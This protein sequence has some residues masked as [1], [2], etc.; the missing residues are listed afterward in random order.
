[1]RYSLQHSIAGMAACGCATIVR[2]SLQARSDQWLDAHR[3][4]LRRDQSRC[5]WRS[6]RLSG[7]P[8]AKLRHS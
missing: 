6:A 8:K 2:K 1:M 3:M 4:H 7:Y 5:I